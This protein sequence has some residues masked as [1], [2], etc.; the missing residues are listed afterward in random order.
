MKKEKGKIYTYRVKKKTKNRDFVVIHVLMLRK[1]KGTKVACLLV[2]GCE[3][4][5]III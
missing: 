3:K 5:I 1:K 2:A 4:I